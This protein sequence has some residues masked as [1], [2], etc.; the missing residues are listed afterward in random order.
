MLY[1]YKFVLEFYHHK[2]DL[3]LQRL[4]EQRLRALQA[5][6]LLKLAQMRVI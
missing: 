4:L 3:L 1:Q 6:L 2:L 5:T